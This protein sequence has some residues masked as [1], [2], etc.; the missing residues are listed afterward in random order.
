MDDRKKRSYFYLN[1]VL[2][3]EIKQV[4]L[5]NNVTLYIKTMSL[6]NIVFPL[7]LWKKKGEVKLDSNK[8]LDF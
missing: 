7:N 1:Q 8:Q 6:Y 4:L 3:P 2:L 5:A